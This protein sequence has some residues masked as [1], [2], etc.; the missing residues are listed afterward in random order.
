MIK[1]SYCIL[2]IIYSVNRIYTF[3][4]ILWCSVNDDLLTGGLKYMLSVN[5]LISEEIHIEILCKNHEHCLCAYVT[6]GYII[7]LPSQ[8]KI[9]TVVINFQAAFNLN[10]DKELLNGSVEVLIHAEIHK[11]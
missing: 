1:T 8:C 3:F 7:C 6:C 4:H 2:K 5:F 9:K 10:N 11:S